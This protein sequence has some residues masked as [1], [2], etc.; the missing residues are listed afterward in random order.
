MANFR[1]FMGNFVDENETRLSYFST[2]HSLYH[3]PLIYRS[4]VILN[5][6]IQKKM[7]RLMRA[8]IKQIPFD[9]TFTWTIF[10]LVM[11]SSII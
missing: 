6:Q 9:L 4:M 2:P 5:N 11:Q 1:H 10:A 3:I 8:N 7:R